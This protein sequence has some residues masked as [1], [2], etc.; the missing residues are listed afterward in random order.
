MS[1]CALGAAPDGGHHGAELSG[2]HATTFTVTGIAAVTVGAKIAMNF[3][4][5]SQIHDVRRG[6]YGRSDASTRG[7]AAGLSKLVA[8]GC[9]SRE[10]TLRVETA[11]AGRRA[12][13][14]TYA[15]RCMSRRSAASPS[16]STG[17][18]AKH[19]PPRFMRRLV[20][21][22]THLIMMQ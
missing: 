11:P 1:A 12:F 4:A 16:S 8:V 18:I 13:R 22:G 14:R 6:T 20:I 5:R 2:G 17:S 15:S 9:Q 21:A 7:G 19:P 10:A 3:T